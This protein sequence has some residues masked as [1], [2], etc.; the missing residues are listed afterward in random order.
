MRLYKLFVLSLLGA[1][2]AAAQDTRG[3]ISGTVVDPQGAITP[4]AVITVTNLDTKVTTQLKT[5]SSGYYL[6]PLLLPGNYEV[7][8]EVPGFKK[9]VRSG[10]VL[11]VSQHMS[12]G[13][14]LEV[15]AVSESVTVT[16]EAPLLDT[17][18]VTAGQNLGRQSVESLPVFSNMTVLMARF[19]PAVNASADVQYVAQGYVNRTSLDTTALGAVGGNE[20]TIDGGSNNGSDRRLAVSPN[21]EMIQEMRVDTANFDAAFGHGTGL[22]IT[23]MTRSGVN[24]PHGSASGQY[25][26]L[27]WN[28]ANFF[29]RQTYWRNIANAKAAG[30]TAMADQL[31]SKPILPAGTG[32][33]VALTLGGPVYIPKVIN[34]KD[35]FFFFLNYSWNYDFRIGVNATGVNT[36]P[37]AAARAGDFSSLLNVNPQYQIYDPLT[38]APDPARPGHYIRQPFT[39]NKIPSTRVI[40][41]MYNAYLKLLPLSNADPLSAN[42][43]PFNNYR[44]AGAPDL[45]HNQIWGNRLDYNLSDKHRFF[46]RWSRSHFTEALNDWT[47][48]NTPGLMSD[49]TVRRQLSGTANWTYARSAQ[50]VISAQVTA[51]NFF[52]GADYIKASSFKPTD[53]G[54]PAYMDQKCILT[55][56]TLP[57]VSWAGYDPLGKGG[58]RGWHTR[59]TQ[60][61]VDVTEVL[62]RHTLKFGTDIRYLSRTEINPGTSAGSF[63]FD[64]TYTRKNDDT[65]VAPAGNLGLSWAAFMLGVPTT[66]TVTAND[67]YA[68]QNP[69]YA[70]YAQ[71][72]WRVTRSLTLNFG[73]RLEYELGMTERYNRM[74]VGWDPNVKLPISDAATAAYAAN[75]LKE[76]PASSFAV[77]GG[78]LYAN[79]QGLGRRA[80]KN[81]VMAMPRFA[82]AWEVNQK[83]V[84]R[85]GYGMYY[86]TLNA[87][88]QVPNQLG[89]SNSTTDVS[90]NNF[91]QTWNS[92][93]P[94]A[95]ISVLTDPFPVRADG[96]RFEVPYGNALGAMMAAGTSF[97]YGN[98]QQEHARL[99]RWRASLQRQLTPNMAI[100]VDY[101]GIYSGNA[102][103]NVKVDPLPAQYWN[104]TKVRNSAL[105]S[106]M[107]SNV[108]NPF[109]INNFASL[110]T[111]NPLLYSRLSAVSFF[112][113]PTIAKNQLLRAFPEMSSLTANNLPLRKVKVHSLDIQF[114]RRLAKG[115]SMNMGLSFNNAKE[116]STVL[117]EYDLAPTQWLPSTNAMPYRITGSGVYQLPFGKGGTWLKTGVMNAILGGWQLAGTF[118]QQPGPLLSWG[119]IFF[120]G[121]IDDIKKGGNTLN[122]WFNTNAGFE[123]DPAKVPTGFQ[124]RLFPTLIDGLRRDKTR[125]LNSSIQ[126]SIS[127]TEKLR[128][129]LGMNAINVL[130]RS[131][132][133]APSLDPTNTNFGV[134]TSNSAT[135]CRWLTFTAKFTF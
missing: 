7:T 18:T 45:V 93:N 54:L 48:Y 113:S 27:R 124:A 130:N 67:T 80:W 3:D 47:Y 52:E 132:F 90:S 105:A 106:D 128:F 51:N 6:A 95:G 83:T 117:N 41:P 36:V 14:T 115:F 96:T 33:S 126:R 15:G 77:L 103:M 49:D 1:A 69:Y 76:L 109:Y 84:V 28:S 37:T 13:L 4:G 32:K 108:T 79:S 57:T 62:G 56:C 123:K 55:K 92:G 64:N 38:V 58:A 114:Q 23:M 122:Q 119:N 39:G 100:E 121:N 22:G 19:V 102:G 5:N 10:L 50:T 11:S 97:S 135:A 59:N 134:I 9:L 94:A 65:S 43:E 30:N 118:E 40:N 46:F 99:Q 70:G 101:T 2:F 21:S 16:T 125:L 78:S 31:A 74:L 120:Y 35:K 129:Q 111:S 24:D 112:T 131:H 29:Q 87:T 25:W 98:L 17:N 72:A 66:S 53:V 26:N 68:S 42:Q 8:V 60:G 44:T 82:F 104:T 110:K 20:W 88:F 127:L 34:G 81:Q 85:G 86:D 91:G 73:V 107:N 89:Y 75:P 71:E 63:A 116:W 12:L 133:G 61:S